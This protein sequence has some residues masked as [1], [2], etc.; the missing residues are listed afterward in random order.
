MCGASTHNGLSPL[1]CRSATRAS[2]AGGANNDKGSGRGLV[3]RD[4]VGQRDIR[5]A[6]P[7]GIEPTKMGFVFSTWSVPTGSWRLGRPKTI[8]LVGNGLPDHLMVG[9]R[10]DRA[11][12]TFPELMIGAMRRV[13]R[14]GVCVV[15]FSACGGSDGTPAEL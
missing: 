2:E 5:L 12:L 13:F 9:E 8:Q 7:T 3:R 14:A 4:F 11:T 10:R 1:Y 15:V 6:A